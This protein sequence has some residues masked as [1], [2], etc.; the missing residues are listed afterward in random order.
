MA[1]CLLHGPSLFLAFF[2]TSTPEYGLWR[3]GMSGLLTQCMAPPQ[4]GCNGILTL[5]TLFGT[6][7][8]RTCNWEYVPLRPSPTQG[9]FLRLLIWAPIFVDGHTL[10]A[11]RSGKC[12]PAAE[13]RSL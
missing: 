4:P 5:P 12:N 8:G 3:T 10:T 9:L 2:T 13:M 1:S 7:D 6:S 11:L